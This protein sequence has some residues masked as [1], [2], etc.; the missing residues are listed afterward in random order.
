MVG[1]AG[2]AVVYGLYQLNMP[3]MTEVHG[4]KPHNE[5]VSSSQ[6]KAMWGSA[7]TVGALFLL[8]KDATVFTLGGLMFLYEEWSYRHA[9][10]VHPMS[11]KVQPLG[12]SAQDSLDMGASTPDSTQNPDPYGYM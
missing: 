10:A 5:S 4:A 2:V 1:V 11:G 3:N 9:N 7:A 12:P 6:K 8:T